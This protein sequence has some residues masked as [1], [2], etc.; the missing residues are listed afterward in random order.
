MKTLTTKADPENCDYATLGV[1]TEY[2]VKMADHG[3]SE[4]QR[5]NT[6]S[7]MKTSC[8]A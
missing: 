5:M 3:K 2:N 1:T 7:T 4:W 8:H 6:R